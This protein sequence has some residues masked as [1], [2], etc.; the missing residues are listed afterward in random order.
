MPFWAA[1]AALTLIDRKFYLEPI[2]IPPSVV[3][4]IELFS[5][6]QDPVFLAAEPEDL[7]RPKFAHIQSGLKRLFVSTCLE[8]Q[9][10]PNT[11][12]IQNFLS[13]QPLHCA[14]GGR[15]HPWLLALRGWLNSVDIELR[16][17]SMELNAR[18]ETAAAVLLPKFRQLQL[19]LDFNFT[20]GQLTLGAR[21][22]YAPLG[23]QI[24]FAATVQ[25]LS[26]RMLMRRGIALPL[27]V[28]LYEVDEDWKFSIFRMI[29]SANAPIFAWLEPSCFSQE[30]LQRLDQVDWDN[31]AKTPFYR[32][33]FVGDEL[34]LER[35]PTLAIAR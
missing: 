11:F 7:Q 1:H 2:G 30:F 10:L 6:Q 9:K 23:Q 34:Q 24:F 35:I 22:D 20:T 32:P 15:F 27:A 17:F 29:L 13:T 18:Y 5:Q 16:E 12:E 33:R 4:S 28:D 26:Q 3:A 25:M 21:S 14:R 31:P 19:E 8:S